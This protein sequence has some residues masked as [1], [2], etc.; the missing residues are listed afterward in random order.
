MVRHVVVLMPQAPHEVAW[1]PR[2]PVKWCRTKWCA[3][4]WSWHHSA[5]CSGAA[6]G[7]GGVA[8]PHEVALWKMMMMPP[9]PHDV[10]L[11]LKMVLVP[12][13]CAEWRCGYSPAE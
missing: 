12:Q 11:L 7:D 10:V 4:Q 3:I 6:E 2:V 9:V 8:A 13:R 1:M 5:A